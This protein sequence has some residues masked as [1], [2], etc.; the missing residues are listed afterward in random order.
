MLDLGVPLAALSSS[1]RS[2]C[3]GQWGLEEFL[4]TDFVVL[5]WDWETPSSSL[6]R[7]G[8]ES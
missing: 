1:H 2:L 4:E 3:Y 8:L 7:H 6:E 5:D